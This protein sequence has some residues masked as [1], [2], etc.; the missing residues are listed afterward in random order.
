MAKS[1]SPLRYPGGKSKIYDKVKNLII[2]NSFDNRTYVE[3]FAGGFGIGIGLLL[4]NTVKSA[5]LNDFDSHIYNFWYSVFH[6]TEELLKMISD[7]PVTVEERNKQKEVYQDVSADVLNDGFATFF[8]N[9]V[10]FSG[11]ITGGPIGGFNQNGTYKI[12]CRFNK[13]EINNKIE[14]I[15]TLL[16]NRIKIYNCDATKLITVELQDN[17]TNS[18]FN[19][20]PP[21]VKKGKRLYAN[22][23]I[24]EDHRNFERIITENLSNTSWIVTYDDCELIRDIYQR[25][26]MVEYGIQHNVSG[27]SQGREIVFTNIN[28]D[29]FPW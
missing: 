18:F 5:V 16:I 9:R 14:K 2:T 10:N 3:P 1:P 24:E 21:Y 25:H 8:L 27:S 23:F 7:T 29:L 19:I 12:D 20:D 4:D 15:A 13:K 6:H 11:V 28:Q 17:L 22:Y 26:H